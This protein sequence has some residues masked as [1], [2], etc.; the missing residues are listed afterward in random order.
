MFSYKWGLYNG[1]V[2]LKKD[3]SQESLDLNKVWVVNDKVSFS[4]RFITQKGL[5]L[6]KV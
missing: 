6:K 2:N 5:V 1:T 4:R 3:Y